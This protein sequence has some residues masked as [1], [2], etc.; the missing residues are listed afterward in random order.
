MREKLYPDPVVSQL[1]VDRDRSPVSQPS[2]LVTPASGMLAQPHATDLD[3]LKQSSSCA[4]T[5]VEVPSGVHA[6]TVMPKASVHQLSAAGF[7]PAP[8]V[9]VHWGG[10]ICEGSSPPPKR[11][12]GS[13]HEGGAVD[14][15]R[16][17]SED[18]YGESSFRA[19]LFGAES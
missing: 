1:F 16:L 11:L 18:D 9:G 14:G 8:R 2:Q 4:S 19:S 5:M 17:S 13:F 10:E 3:G 15:E 7:T 6:V 12:S